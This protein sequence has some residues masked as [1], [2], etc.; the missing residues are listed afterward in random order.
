LVVLVKPDWKETRKYYQRKLYIFTSMLYTVGCSDFTCKFVWNICMKKCVEQKSKTT[1]NTAP[2]SPV[3]IKPKTYKAF[4]ISSQASYN[5]GISS[6]GGR[7]HP[8]RASP[9][10]SAEWWRTSSAASAWR[11]R[12]FLHLSPRNRVWLVWA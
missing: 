4:S 11:S 3:T 12:F 7:S 9:S 8:H 1:I 6:F 2:H 5:T 10:G